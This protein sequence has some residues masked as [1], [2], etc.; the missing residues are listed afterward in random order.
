MA[1]DVWI[2]TYIAPIFYNL[3]YM[4]LT[5]LCIAV[6]ILLI[7]RFADV[8]ISPFWK[9][10]MWFL[11]FFALALPFRLQS[12]IPL[13][14]QFSQV[15]EIS[16]REEELAL[17]Q[18]IMAYQSTESLPSHLPDSPESLNTLQVEMK[19]LQLKSQL[20]DL[21]I[22][23]VWLFGFIAIA[24]FLF[25]MAMRLRYKVK[26][27]QL[28]INT[29]R[30][31]ALL[32][33]C[34]SRLNLHQPIEI[35]LQTYIQT[36]ALMGIFRP[37]ILLPS[38]AESLDDQNLS[39]VLLHELA[40]LKRRDLLINF[41]LIVFQAVYWFN[42]L[43]WVLFKYVRQDMELANDAYVL[44]RIGNEHQREYSLSL[45]AVLAKYSGVTLVPRMLCMLDNK[46]NIERRIQMIQL[47]KLFQKR[48]FSIA[49]VSIVLMSCMGLLFLTTQASQTGEKTA[50][51]SK[52]LI[53]SESK[54]ESETE[55]EVKIEATNEAKNEVEA[56]YGTY[57]FVHWVYT[58]PL[59]SAFYTDDYEEK[60]SFTPESLLI[61][62]EFQEKSMPIT[63]T[64]K[65]FDQ[66][67][68]NT[69]SILPS[70]SLDLS[71]FTQIK[72]YELLGAKENG[73]GIGYEL[74]FLDD[75]IW[76]VELRAND[77][78]G[79]FL[80]SILE[81]K[82]QGSE[83]KLIASSDETPVLESESKPLSLA[84]YLAQVVT[85][86]DIQLYNEALDKNS[87][88]HA[89][90]S[91]REMTKDEVSRSMILS[92]SYK[93]D[94][95]RPQSP[96]PLKAGES[97]VY[98]DLDQD[99]IYYPS[100]ELTDEELLQFIDH[101]ARINYAVQVRIE[102][103]GILLKA[104]ADDL[105]EVEAISKAKE[106]IEKLFQV[107]FTPL[108]IS[109]NFSALKGTNERQWYV[110]FSPLKVRTLL[111]KGEA[112]WSYFVQLNA[113]SGEVENISA[114]FQNPNRKPSAEKSSAENPSTELD[115]E[116]IAN[117]S[118][119]WIEKAKS[120]YAEELGA[121][122]E[123]KEAQITGLSGNSDPAK[124]D[125]Y[126]FFLDRGVVSVVLTL[127]NESQCVIELSYADQSVRGI[128]FQ[129]RH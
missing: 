34:K 113:E 121:L 57:T 70:H 25:V 103:E 124:K 24:T 36:P 43:L 118:D 51:E 50:T 26:R 62:N 114:N 82:K 6:V 61:E 95:L 112:F 77:N 123:I 5:G 91:N 3:L 79:T 65:E 20:F 97:E 126:E 41:L 1:F 21:V 108:E 115:Q 31:M 88:N 32:E 99:T 109:A 102:R 81:M 107:D 17:S 76:L 119:F 85:E 96:L 67:L 52:L 60:Y 110:S 116:A 105:T 7:R 75:T 72:R 38:Y 80:W 33:Q 46:V 129:Y 128:S 120:V 18:R 53:V 68:F 35:I 74:Y 64:E 4:S 106:G 8:H 12:K 48:R 40:H 86:K 84:E 94:G 56:I 11:A 101:G 73:K 55:S 16:F 104:D 15:K 9:Y 92:D 98:Y 44:S 89:S 45:V 93:Y 66:A 58:N 37:R 127:E 39:H 49:V 83:P 122:L 69:L 117:N 125:I 14:F 30:Y 87:Q 13:L 19:D 29:G 71:G 22:P 59:S 100:R 23:S 42:P 2:A 111:A 63:Y 10:T 28:W 27:N 54:S 90:L 47:G 78:M